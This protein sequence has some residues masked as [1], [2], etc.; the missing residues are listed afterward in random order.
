MFKA[1]K[2]AT[3]R[4]GTHIAGVD[5]LVL[6]V[7]ERDDHELGEANREADFEHGRLVALGVDL[8][9]CNMITTCYTLSSIWSIR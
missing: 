3:M 7:V 4:P 2:V 9:G 5:V 1:C 6:F 8:W